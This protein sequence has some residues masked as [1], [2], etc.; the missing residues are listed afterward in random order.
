[1][2]KKY[3]SAIIKLIVTPTI[4]FVSTALVVL[5]SCREIGEDKLRK[6]SY[7]DTYF[8]PKG[9]YHYENSR[10]CFIYYLYTF[11]TIPII[12]HNIDAV[13]YLHT[14]NKQE[15]RKWVNLYVEN[16]R[17]HDRIKLNRESEN[18][19]YFEF[20][21]DYDWLDNCIMLRIHRSDYFIPLWDKKLNMSEIGIYNGDFS[22]KKVKEL[23]EYL[24]DSNN[25]PFPYGKVIKSSIT[26]KGTKFE[27]NIQSLHRIVGGDNPD[28]QTKIYFYN[29]IYDLD[30]E[31]KVLT[32]VE[33]KLLREIKE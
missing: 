18:D 24:W 26:D 32:F 29:N 31:S 12:D 2:K 23:V 20:I 14:N 7:D 28:G 9:F 4:L 3:S 1:M 30:K 22:S 15:A 16:S 11:D 17:S 19:K 10:D 8:Y 13:I 33:R 25:L 27:H 5:V 21:A 6:L